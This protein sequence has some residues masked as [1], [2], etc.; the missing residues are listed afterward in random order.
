MQEEAG[1]DDDPTCRSGR[2]SSG[3][4]RVI[5]I[6]AEKGSPVDT[7]F[8]RRALAKR[9]SGRRGVDTKDIEAGIRKEKAVASAA[10]TDI[11]DGGIR[12]NFQ[13]DEGCEL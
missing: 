5:D 3:Q 13:R 7:S 2:N 11:N 1:I 6:A 4:F 10:A 12:P 9:N 8:F